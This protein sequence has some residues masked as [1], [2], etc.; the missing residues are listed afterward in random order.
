MIRVIFVGDEPSQTNVTPDVAF[1]GAKCFDTVVKWIK[2]LQPDYYVCLNSDTV[3]QLSDI[4]K[5]EK[6]GFKVIAFGNKASEKLVKWNIPHYKMPHP[7]GLNRKL[8]NK[9]AMALELYHA[10]S[11]LIGLQDEYKNSSNQ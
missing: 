8:N 5:L 2:E 9:Q 3:S 6:F 4:K 7:S 11:Y 1:V 10:H